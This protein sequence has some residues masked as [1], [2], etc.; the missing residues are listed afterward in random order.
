MRSK[1]L[2]PVGE[3][4]LNFLRCCGTYR[5]CKEFDLIKGECSFADHSMLWSE[6]TFDENME[7]VHCPKWCEYFEPKEI[8]ASE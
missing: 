1:Y 3:E 2:G 7:M 6:S 4:D 8:I 5:E